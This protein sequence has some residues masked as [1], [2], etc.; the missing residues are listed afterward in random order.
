MVAPRRQT[1]RRP[2]VQLPHF[3]YLRLS[4]IVNNE[5]QHIGGT[6]LGLYLARELARMHGGDITVTSV[7]GEG[8]EF[9]VTLPLAS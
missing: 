9:V 7:L 8:S 5:N 6:G 4:R 1:A 3:L 2:R